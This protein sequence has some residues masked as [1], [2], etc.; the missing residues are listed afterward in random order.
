MEKLE[1]RRGKSGDKAGDNSAAKLYPPN[2]IVMHKVVHT[3]CGVINR[4]FQGASRRVSTNP[5]HLLLMRLKRYCFSNRV[6]IM[7]L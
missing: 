7:N 5:P 4:V 2:Y 3:I 6:S 1:E